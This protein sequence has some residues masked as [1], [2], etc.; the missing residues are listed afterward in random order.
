MNSNN[1]LNS[2]NGST[3]ERVIEMERKQQSKDLSDSTKMEVDS[4]HSA[5]SDLDEDDLAPNNLMAPGAKSLVKMKMEENR[6]RREDA[7]LKPKVDALHQAKLA[8]E[9]EQRDQAEK[10]K[11]KEDI[12]RRIEENKRKRKREEQERERERDRKRPKIQNK[13]PKVNGN[14]NG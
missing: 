14:G 5:D 8:R 1:I 9:R 10:K 4:D 7:K 12:R 2:V 3:N 11:K 6:K 13:G